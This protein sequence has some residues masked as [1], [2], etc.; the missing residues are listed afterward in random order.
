MLCGTVPFKASNMKELHK[1][2]M[3]GKYH[4]KEE[5]SD[6]AKNLMKAMLDINPKTRINIA[7]ILKHPWMTS[8]PADSPEIFN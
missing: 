7:D 5:V 6:L 8:I 4:F 2:I 3:K 1:M